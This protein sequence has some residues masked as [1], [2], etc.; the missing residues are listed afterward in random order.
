M[1]VL[2]PRYLHILHQLRDVGVPLMRFQVRLKK[3]ARIGE[4][5]L[6]DKSRWARRSLDVQQDVANAHRLFGL[7]GLQ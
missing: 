5:H 7:D 6:G 1:L 4:E 2:S 3:R